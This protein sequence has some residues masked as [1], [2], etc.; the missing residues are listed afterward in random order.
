[1][2]KM[3]Q[4][5][6]PSKHIHN[7]SKKN[8]RL[9]NSFIIQSS[10][11]RNSLLAFFML[12]YWLVSRERINSQQQNDKNVYCIRK[13][14]QKATETEQKL[15]SEMLMSSVY[16]QLNLQSST[17]LSHCHSHVLVPCYVKWKKYIK[18]FFFCLI[19]VG[20]LLP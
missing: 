4:L 10:I 7:F 6:H 2:H 3:L 16:I 9:Y 8:L 5:F 13:F 1:M 18:I 20:P 19:L 14:T 15:T 17:Q 11:K 12:Y